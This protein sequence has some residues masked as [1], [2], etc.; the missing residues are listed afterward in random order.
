MLFLY[1]VW[2]AGCIWLL[3]LLVDVFVN[4]NAT[5]ERNSGIILRT[6]PPR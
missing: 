6:M 4:L 1:A 2:L 3:F 5:A